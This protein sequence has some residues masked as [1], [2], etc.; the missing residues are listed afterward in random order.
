M[1]SETF[2]VDANDA[3]LLHR[4]G[5]R[6]RDPTLLEAALTHR[7]AGGVNNERLE[8]LGDAILGL[9]IADEIYR[10]RPH[11]PEG[12]LSRLRAT[13]VRGSSLAKIGGEIGIGAH[14]RMGS[15]ER[16]SGGFRRSSMLADALEALF[17]AVYCDGG[18]EPAAGL[19]RSL[20]AAR[21]AHLPAADTLKDP[22]TRLQEWLQGQGRPLPEY[23][24]VEVSGA[25]HAR[26]FVM[27][28]RLTDQHT[29]ADGEGVSRRSAEQAAARKLFEHVT[30]S[31]H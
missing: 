11:D 12:D 24:Q 1:I 3:A 2:V 4:L 27:R 10:L 30:D 28:C 25:D 31:D 19:I 18:F 7:S 23:T 9:V 5:Y 29:H 26:Q 13:L 16:R 14:L 15:G 17:G 21:L 20:F 8:F 22:K 6:F